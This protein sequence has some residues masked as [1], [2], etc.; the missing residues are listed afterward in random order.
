LSNPLPED[1]WQG[2]TGLITEVLDRSF[3]TLDNHEAYLCGSPGMIDASIKVLKSKGLPEDMI[4]FD[5]FA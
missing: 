5:K 3:T 2:E 1:K 4:F